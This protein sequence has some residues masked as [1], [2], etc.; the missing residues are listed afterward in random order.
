MWYCKHVIATASRF[1]VSTSLP[2]IKMNGVP[3]PQSFKSGHLKCD[4]RCKQL[5]EW[6][7]FRSCADIEYLQPLSIGLC[8]AWWLGKSYASIYR[9]VVPFSLWLTVVSSGQDWWNNISTDSAMPMHAIAAS[10]VIFT[11]DQNNIRLSGYRALAFAE[12]RAAG[13]LGKASST[14]TGAV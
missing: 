12:K 11:V 13:G 10:L 9:F 2:W 7:N 5:Q 4:S 8:S 6:S 3:W 1:P 14:E